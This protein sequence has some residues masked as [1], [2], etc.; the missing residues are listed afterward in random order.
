MKRESQ[1]ESYG[2]SEDGDKGFQDSVPVGGE[3]A[4]D[5]GGGSGCEDGDEPAAAAR[6]RSG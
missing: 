3:E 1:P 4:E 5:D 6:S 2:S